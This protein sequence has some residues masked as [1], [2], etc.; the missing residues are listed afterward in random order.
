M[1]AVFIGVSGENL[2]K[3][4]WMKRRGR[5]GHIVEHGSAGLVIVALAVE[6][7][8]VIKTNNINEMDIQNLRIQAQENAKTASDLGVTLDNLT[9]VVRRKTESA[10]AAI[11]ALSRATARVSAVAGSIRKQVAE[12]HSTRSQIRALLRTVDPRIVDNIDAGPSSMLVRMFKSDYEKLVHLAKQSESIPLLYVGL[13]L[14]SWEPSEPINDGSFGPTT[15]GEQVEI[16]MTT[17]P[18]VSGGSD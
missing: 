16:G 17:F 5:W 10:D 3:L 2:A 12:D 14:R 6:I 4:K 18:E 15:S 1:A 11:A 7:P 9:E 8:A 13:P